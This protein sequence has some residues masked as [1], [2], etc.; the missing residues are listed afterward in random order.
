MKTN[1]SFAIFTPEKIFF[2][3]SVFKNSV[4]I[5]ELMIGHIKS[6]YE[7]KKWSFQIECIYYL[8]FN[9]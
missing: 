5:H 9:K 4:Q 8:D 2:K 7:E 3:I 6:L 1:Y